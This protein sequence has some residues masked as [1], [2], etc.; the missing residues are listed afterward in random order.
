MSVLQHLKM[1]GQ[2]ISLVQSGLR[3]HSFHSL[4]HE[5]SQENQFSLFLMVMAPMKLLKSF[6]LPSFIVTL[7]YAFHHHIPPWATSCNLLML[8]S[9]D[10][11]SMPGWISVI[12]VELTGSEM[13]KEDFIKEYMQVR[14]ESFCPS[15]IISAFKKSGT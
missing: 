15:T 10:H 11:S 3:N 5:T 2:M 12:T 7:S 4:R 8:A 14:Q 9:L 1:A 13:P 6:T